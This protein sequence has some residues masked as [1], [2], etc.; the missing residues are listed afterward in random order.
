MGLND[1][2]FEVKISSPIYPT[3]GKETLISCLSNIFPKTNWEIKE[4]EV[5]GESKYLTR[6]KSILEDMQIRDTARDHMR[7]RVSGGS[8]AFTLSKQATCNAKINF[9]EQEQPLGP[10]EVEIICDDI[11][12]LIEN[13]TEIEE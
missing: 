1:F 12:M 5:T 3:E 6:F 10:V 13:L 2:N 4:N 9:S 11:V 8:C 7:K